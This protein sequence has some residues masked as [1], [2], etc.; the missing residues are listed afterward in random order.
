MMLT[1]IPHPPS[2]NGACGPGPS[3]RAR[4]QQREVPEQVAEVD[5]R[6]RT[7][8][9]DARA[10]ELDERDQRERPDD[11][12][13]HDRRVQPRVHL[14]HRLRQRQL[15]V[16][17]HPESQPDGR[18]L[19]RHAADEDGRRHDDE[20]QRRQ[21]L[22]QH[23]AD[24]HA[25]TGGERRRLVRDARRRD[26]DAPQEDGADHERTDHRTRGRPSAPRAAGSS[27][28]RRGWTPCRSRRSRR[29]T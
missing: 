17:C 19:D 6:R 3:L 4:S 29:A 2:L 22:G 15:V 26:Q 27:S 7:H 25:G 5:R 13:R 24:D 10:G 9:D 11:D 1:T 16:P 18:R 28:P 14:R 21:G 12:A 8:G 23:L 20:V